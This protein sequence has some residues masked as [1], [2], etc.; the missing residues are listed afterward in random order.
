MIEWTESKYG[1]TA[2]VDRADLI[3]NH[4]MKRNTAHYWEVHHI[5]RIEA[6]RAW[7]EAAAKACAESIAQRLRDGAL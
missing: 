3:V 5:G 2:K 6:G 1:W 7:S 4:P